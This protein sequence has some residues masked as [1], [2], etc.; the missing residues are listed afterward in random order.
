MTVTRNEDGSEF[1][2]GTTAGGKIFHIRQSEVRPDGA[3]VAI[4]YRDHWFCL[5]GNDLESKSTFM[6]LAPVVPFASRRSQI[7]R[8]G[9]DHTR[10]LKS[11]FY[12]KKYQPIL[13]RP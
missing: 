5:A 11:A 2:W 13:L 10:A 8:T 9:L 1:D 7:N 12:D 3:F 6:L 4:P